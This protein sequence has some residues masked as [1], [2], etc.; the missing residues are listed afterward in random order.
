MARVVGTGT[1]LGLGRR[2]PGAPARAQPALGGAQR[3]QNQHV[4]G[5]GV[6][7]LAHDVAA[8]RRAELARELE[9]DEGEEALG[10]AHGL[11]TGRRD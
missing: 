5:L 7:A 6:R 2:G 3:P 11:L 4:A 9:L 10:I 8:V 1:G